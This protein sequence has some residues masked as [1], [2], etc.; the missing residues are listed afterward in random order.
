MSCSLTVDFTSDPD[1]TQDACSAS[2]YHISSP[3]L[4]VT[5]VWL[6][7]LTGEVSPNEPS[8][9]EIHRLVWVIPFGD[10][11]YLMTQG[12]RGTECLSGGS[13]RESVSLTFPAFRDCWHS[14]ACDPLPSAKPV[15]S[16]WV[17]LILS[18]L[19]VF[20][21]CIPLALWLHWAQLDN[22]G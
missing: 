12:V 21:F 22:L 10:V 2:F 20:L 8:I 1:F 3:S 14:L 16:G 15:M 19:W 6:Y 17:I 11:L 13:R 5:C 4:C 18:S 9:V 7:W